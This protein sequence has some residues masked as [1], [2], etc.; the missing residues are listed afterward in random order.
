[1]RA[2]TDTYFKQFDRRQTRWRTAPK[3]TRVG[4][5]KHQR[6]PLKVPFR[7]GMSQLPQG[8]IYPPKFIWNEVVDPN[9]VS[10]I[11]LWPSWN[12]RKP[13]IYL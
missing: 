6:V 5:A 9:F 3:F 2:Q 13:L 11:G 8:G 4:D 10:L 1:M 7:R 12:K